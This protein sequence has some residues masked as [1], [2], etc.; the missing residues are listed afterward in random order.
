M[1]A[2][3]L[4]KFIAE[5]YSTQIRI[6]NYILDIIKVND[7]FLNNFFNRDFLYFKIVSQTFFELL[8]QCGFSIRIYPCVPGA[9]SGYT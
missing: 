3:V 8:S 1:V 5:K 2:G 4:Y 6:A 9:G 7:P